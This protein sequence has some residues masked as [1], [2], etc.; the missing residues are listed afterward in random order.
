[1]MQTGE[2]TGFAVELREP[3][4][5]WI[6]FTTPERL[7]GLTQSIKRDLVETVTQ[8]TMD[9]RVRLLVFTGT[10]RAFCAGDDISGHAPD[11][12]GTPLVPPIHPGHDTPM[13][14]YDGLRIL[15]QA[16]NVA[17]RSCDK[18]SIAAINGV[19]IQ[20]GFSLALACDFRIA[21]DTA[22]LGSA[23]LRFGLLPDEGGQ[24]LLVQL[25][26]V[27][28]TMD[29]LMRKRIVGAAEAQALG[30]LHEVVPAANL[31]AATMALATELANG[32][33][34]SMRLLKRSI[35]NA[36]EM[37]QE[38]SFDEI[39]SKTAISDHHPDAREGVAAW[40]EK[41]APRF[42]RWLEPNA[43]AEARLER[44]LETIGRLEGEI[45]RA[46]LQSQ[47]LRQLEQQL[48]RQATR[49]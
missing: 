35:Y 28:R 16:L 6:R 39:A 21:A 9:N 47:V 7:N 42:N 41:R 37:S 26:G 2:F 25:M 27:A 19:A 17:V 48:I 30:L 3:G 8:A 44:V 10:G 15:S 31:E 32:P 34:V 12:G 4:I 29:F 11:L 49:P 24:Y 20:T 45:R 40:K 18:L 38:Q 36:W 43:G 23:T 14:T 46:G 5:A 22:K 13:G 33:Q 1:M